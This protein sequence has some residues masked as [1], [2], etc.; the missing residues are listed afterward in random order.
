MVVMWTDKTGKRL[1]R[2]AGK[3]RYFTA[4]G[5][6]VTFPAFDDGT[7]IIPPDGDGINGTLEFYPP[8]PWKRSVVCVQPLTWGARLQWLL[9]GA[10]TIEVLLGLLRM[11][12]Y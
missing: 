9:V 11:A 7:L 12:S 1:M 10:A 8:E 2:R 5:R 3:A 4:D 6:T